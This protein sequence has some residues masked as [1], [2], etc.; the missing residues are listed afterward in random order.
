M[1]PQTD[2]GSPGRRGTQTQAGLTAGKLATDV[3]LSAHT[4]HC[5]YN[6]CQQSLRLQVSI[7]LGMRCCWQLQKPWETWHL[8]RRS[9]TS[10][11]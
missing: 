10:S 1:L 11:C 9:P 2:H 5:C 7:S 4:L 8:N 6:M 3:E